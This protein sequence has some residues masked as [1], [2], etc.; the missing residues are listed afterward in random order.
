M[1]TLVWITLGLGGV[2]L[3]SSCT[4][5]KLCTKDS[6]PEFRLC[7]KDYDSQTEYGA[8]VDFYEA[9]GWSCIESY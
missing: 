4:K 5:C 8:T 9:Q 3:L 1:K 6:E 2:A 7:E